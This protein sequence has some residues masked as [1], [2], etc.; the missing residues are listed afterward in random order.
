M[1]T[2]C[3][4]ANDNNLEVLPHTIL[5]ISTRQP[6]II[7]SL[8]HVNNGFLKFCI[9]NNSVCE[10]Q[11]RFSKNRQKTHQKKIAGLR[12]APSHGAAPLPITKMG[13]KRLSA[14][15]MNNQDRA[16]SLFLVRLTSVIFVLF[17]D[18]PI[19]RSAKRQQDFLQICNSLEILFSIT[20]RNSIVEPLLEGL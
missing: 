8:G 2:N 7:V 15:V 17:F 14:V 1:P 10:D 20:T 16:L 5:Y 12:P 13:A 3:V 19:V 11:K 4:Q 6:Q 9:S 18:Q